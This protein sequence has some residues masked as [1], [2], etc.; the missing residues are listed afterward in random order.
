MLKSNLFLHLL[1]PLR[2]VTLL[3]QPGSSHRHGTFMKFDT[4]HK[5]GLGYDNHV[6]TSS[7]FDCD[8]MFSS[9]SD[10]S[11]PASPVYNRY[12]SREGYHSVPPPYTR[13]FMPHKPNLVFHDAPNVTETV[14]TAFNVELSP[15]KPEKDLSQPN[16]SSAPI[17][18]D[19]VFDSE[20]ESETE[21]TQTVPSFVQPPEHVKT[22]RPSVQTVEHPIPAETLKQDI[23]KSKGHR[24]SKNRKA[25]FVLLTKSRLVPLTAAR[26]VTAAVPQPHVTRPRPVKNVVPKS[27]SPPRRNINRRPFTKPGNFSQKVTTAEVSQVNAVKGVQGNGY[28]NLNGIC[29]ISL[30]LKLS[31]EDMLL[32]V[33]IQKVVRSQMCDKKNSV[34]FIDTECI[35]LSSDFKLPDAGHATLDESN[36]WHRRLGHINFKTM[37]KLVKVVADD[38][39]RFSW[40]FFLATN[41]ETSLIL[42]TFI[43]GMEN[44]LSLKVKIIRSDNETE[45]K[46]HDLNQFCGMKGIKRE[47]SVARTP[48]HNGITERKNMT[49]IKATRTMLADSLL[50]IPFWAVS[51]NTAYYVQ[52]RV[53]VTKPHNKTP[54]ELLHGRTPSIGFVRPFGYLVTILNTLDPLGKFDGKADERFL[55]GYSL[56]QAINLTLVQE[57]FNAKKVGEGNVQQ[58]VLFPSWSS[59]F[60]D[61]QITDDDTT[62]KVKENEFEDKQPESEVYVSPSSSAKTQKHDDKTKREAKGKS[63]VEFT[64]FTVVEPNST[65]NTNTFSVAGPCNTAVSSNFEIGGKYSFVDPSQYPDDPNMPALEDIT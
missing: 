16:R 27:H 40:V 14:H 13:I 29:P 19:W 35:V 37:N 62:F 11:M 21:H 32:L 33:E 54:Y 56:V 31:M 28:G 39:S 60:K 24:N 41:D 61:P 23:P 30:T 3:W 64:P 25:C 6:F 48:Q 34:L 12:Q 2:I 1:S 52:N 65:N 51:V 38:Y 10:A 26:T 9:E 47:F 15:T 43:T 22:L 20:D 7:M 45:F 17:I 5:T 50:P 18:K 55:V 53:L 63:P 58:Y 46:N 36:L 57:L 44:Q 8:E 59:G 49:L 4:H 42:K